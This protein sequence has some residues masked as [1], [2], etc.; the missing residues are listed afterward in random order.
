MKF[1]TKYYRIGDTPL[2]M[3][4]WLYECCSKVDPAIVVR[5]GHQI[6]RILN[7]KVIDNQPHYQF[8]MEDIFSNKDNPVTGEFTDL[9]KLIND[10]FASVLQDDHNDIPAHIHEGGSPISDVNDKRK[11]SSVLAKSDT[12]QIES[13]EVKGGEENKEDHPSVHDDFIMYDKQTDTGSE[14]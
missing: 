1:E 2:T 3:Q 4:V 14:K 10:H 6:L 11:Y 8:L 7:W 13:F 9:R 12:V 5:V